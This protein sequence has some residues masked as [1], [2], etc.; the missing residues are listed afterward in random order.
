ESPVLSDNQEVKNLI[1]GLTSQTLSKPKTQDSSPTLES[2][3]S[4]LQLNEASEKLIQLLTTSHNTQTISQSNNLDNSKTV[5]LLNELQNNQDITS[6]V[7]QMMSGVQLS[8]QKIEKLEKE[9]QALENQRLQEEARKKQKL[10]DEEYQKLKSEME[11]S[12][13]QL[14]LEAFETMVTRFHEQP[15]FRKEY[16]IARVGTTFPHAVTTSGFINK[17]RSL[18]S[19]DFIRQLCPTRESKIIFAEEVYGVLEE[20]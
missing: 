19:T 1:S 10:I 13:S 20:I 2:E 18:V 6:V 12:N 11:D 17:K 3:T 15:D 7:E 8:N 5:S 9:K 14:F 4:N 16:I